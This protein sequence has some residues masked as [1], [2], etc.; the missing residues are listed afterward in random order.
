MMMGGAEKGLSYIDW[1]DPILNREL[2]GQ[3]TPP[4]INFYENPI[5]KVIFAG[6]DDKI[7]NIDDVRE[8]KAKIENINHYE[9][10]EGDH[11]SFFIGKD[12]SY[13][14]SMIEQIKLNI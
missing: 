12:M 11:L 14:D 3:D 2:Y 1:K 6:I 5:P 4:T 9:E 7:V 13:V 8:I 10:I